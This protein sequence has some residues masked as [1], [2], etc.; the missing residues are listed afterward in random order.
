LILEK[1]HIRKKNQFSSQN[2]LV[3]FCRIF[4]ILDFLLNEPPLFRIMQPP[5]FRVLFLNNYYLVKST[6]SPIFWDKLEGQFV[7]EKR[8]VSLKR[9]VGGY[10]ERKIQLA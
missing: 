2:Q 3:N 1:N 8:G 10:L 4:S 5:Y 7:A 9:K 6:H